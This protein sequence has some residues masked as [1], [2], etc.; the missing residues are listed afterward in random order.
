M[1]LN[2]WVLPIVLVVHKKFVK[3][4]QRSRLLGIFRFSRGDCI[5]AGRAMA[6]SVHV[7]SIGG[8]HEYLSATR[9]ELG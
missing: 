6:N 9:R 7:H 3:G 8:R 2:P 5:A 4:Y 1:A